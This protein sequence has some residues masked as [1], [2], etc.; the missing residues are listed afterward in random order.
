M[1]KKDSLAILGELLLAGDVCPERAS[2]AF[3]YLLSLK[4]PYTFVRDILNGDYGSSFYHMETYLNAKEPFE[5][6][7]DYD[8]VEFDPETGRLGV[9]CEV[10][11]FIAWLDEYKTIWTVDT[12][13]EIAERERKNKEWFDKVWKPKIQKAFAE[14]S[15]T[16]PLERDSTTLT[17]GGTIKVAKIK[18]DGLADYQ[19]EVKK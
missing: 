14:T 1:N 16:E 4:L 17:D 2:L 9:W 18:L 12:R 3:D 13:E 11:G 5:V 6:S 7:S 19:K 15:Y 10:D 8:Y